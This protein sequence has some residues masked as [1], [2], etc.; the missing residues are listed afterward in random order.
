MSFNSLDKIGPMSLLNKLVKNPNRKFQMKST[1]PDHAI[2]D[3]IIPKLYSAVAYAIELGK[4]A[5]VRKDF[6]ERYE[7]IFSFVAQVEKT[8][9]ENEYSMRYANQFAEALDKV[10]S[11][12]GTDYGHNATDKRI[13]LTDGEKPIQKRQQEARQDEIDSTFKRAEQSFDFFSKLKFFNRDLVVIGA[14]GS[15]KTTLTLYAKEHIRN[16]GVVIS[17]QRILLLPN[18][19]NVKN[20]AIT[21]DELKEIQ[22]ADK[23]IRGGDIIQI[24]SEFTRL[25]QNLLASDSMANKDYAERARQQKLN[26]KSIDPPE[27]TALQNAL[28]IWND[29]FRSPVLSIEDGMNIIARKGKSSYPGNQMSDGEKEILFLIAQVLQCPK[30]GHVIVDEPEMHLHPTIHRML[31]DRLEQER[32][33]ATFIYLTHDLEFATSRISASKVW[34]RGFEEPDIFRIHEIPTSVLP[35]PL[36]LELLGSRHNILFCEGTSGS[37]DSKLYELLFPEFVIKPVGGCLSVIAFTKAYNMIPDKAVRAIGLIDADFHET[38][39]IQSLEPQKIYATRLAEAENLLLSE[40]ILIQL[41]L[42][43]NRPRG[44]VNDIEQKVLNHLSKHKEMQVMRYASNRL[45]QHLSDTHVH[46]GESLE[47]IE[48]NYLR[49]QSNI[50]LHDWVAARREEID[51]ILET[52]SYSD[53]IRI[54]NDKGLRSIVNTALGVKD[55]HRLAI[56]ALEEDLNLRAS[57]ASAFPI[58]KMYTDQKD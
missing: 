52:Q 24:Q 49:Y 16:Y 45:N 48:S 47:E 12:F 50:K 27:L 26:G 54:I 9:R 44:T 32:R 38:A 34:L 58:D 37:L 17:A 11:A 4:S 10:I 41:C 31:W 39:R 57:I 15:G 8:I 18:F 1:Y 40:A 43:L 7:D 13:Y 46:P 28:T 2:L 56:E 55:F 51:R 36:L 53:A 29:I 14:N 30:D 23:R 19:N 42:R 35:K 3:N 33:D 5:D 6:M 20:A 22:T 25:M 21:T